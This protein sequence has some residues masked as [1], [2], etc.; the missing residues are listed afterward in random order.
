M[1][2]LEKKSKKELLDIID[3]L[4]G[5][6]GEMQGVEAKQEAMECSLEGVGF[7]VIQDRDNTFKILEIAFD[8]DSKA[9]TISKV[10]EVTTNGYEYALYEAKKFL[11]ERVMNKDNLNHLK[12]KSNG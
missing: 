1:S 7:S 5:K 4:R 12:E 11:I 10:T 3:Q 2:D 6:L 9:A 8:F